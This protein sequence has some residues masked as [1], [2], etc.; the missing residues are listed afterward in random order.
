MSKRTKLA[1]DIVTSIAAFVRAR[2]VTADNLAL[3]KE[4]FDKMGLKVRELKS[5]FIKE[6][7]SRGWDDLF[8]P[9]MDCIRYFDKDN[10]V[11]VDWFVKRG[12][13]W[14]QYV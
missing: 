11:P 14:S 9:V 13:D 4:S 5:F 7:M 12:N 8:F 3:L 2:N 1:E 6:R 10:T